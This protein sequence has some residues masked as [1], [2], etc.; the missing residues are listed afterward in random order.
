[1]RIYEDEQLLVWNKSA[2]ISVFP[3]HSDPE[4]PCVLYEIQKYK[5]K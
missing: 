5:Y 2:G 1:M 3:R 4:A